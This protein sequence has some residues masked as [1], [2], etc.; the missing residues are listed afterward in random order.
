MLIG[1]LIQR[2]HSL[3]AKGVHSDE[4]RLMSRHIYNKL[5][6]VRS[7]LLYR[8]LN[9]R[10][11]ISQWNY[12]TLS[13]VEMVTVPIQDC[14]C[15]PPLGCYILRTKHPLPKP[16]TK[17]TK[18]LIKSVTSLDGQTIYA[19]IDWEDKKYKADN[20]YTAKKP[21]YFIRNKYLYITTT[22]YPEVITIT[23]LFQDPLEVEAFP[24]YCCNDAV[25]PET[26]ISVYD[27]EF[28]IDDEL[29]DPMIELCFKEL[30]QLFNSNLEDGTNNTNDNTQQNSK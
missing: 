1:E 28:P 16:L 25:K 12:Q 19:E 5:L 30:I 27:K 2:I 14:P 24:S 9:S 13:C 11:K 4:T 6:S 8:K 20:K 29:I 3:Y 15:I 21:D 18:H 7:V 22:K 17:Y 23:G 26:C 10:Q